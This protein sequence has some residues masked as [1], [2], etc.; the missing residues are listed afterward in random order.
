VTT[1]RWPA[2]RH[3][4]PRRAAAGSG[5]RARRRFPVLVAAASVGLLVACTLVWQATSA[6]FVG[7]TA[8]PANSWE[9]GVVQLTNDRGATALFSTATEGLLVP[10]SSGSRCITVTYTGTVDTAASGV[11][12]YGAMTT[13]SPELADALQVTVQM[14]TTA[15]SPAPNADCLPAAFPASPV[16]YAGRAFSAFPTTYATGIGDADGD[17]VGDWRPSATSDRTRTYKI[18]YSLPAG[19]YP[20]SMQGKK[21]GMTFTWEVRSSTPGA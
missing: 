18:S 6:A 14:S 4:P 15:V 7:T 19:P 13:D 1:G 12:L 5:I 2:P 17:A 3:T 16:S 20:A 8:T 21:V 11:R 10:G 9:T